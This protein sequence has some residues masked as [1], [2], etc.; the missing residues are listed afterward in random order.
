MKFEDWLAEVPTPL[1]LDTLWKL[2][3]YRLG[4]FASDL[5][6]RDVTK[7]LRDRRTISLADQLYRSLGGNQRNHCRGIF[8]DDRKGTARFYE[9]ALGS[10]REARDHYYKGRFILGAEVTEHRVKLLTGIIRL[11]LRMVPDQR[12]KNIK[13][14][15]GRTSRNHVIT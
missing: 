7:L 11:M 14:V 6:W 2:E 15:R 12:G 10:A 4:L 9:Y 8:A 13:L 3:A 5:G 1:T